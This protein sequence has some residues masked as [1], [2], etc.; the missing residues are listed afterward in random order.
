MCWSFRP[1]LTPLQFQ[2]MSR[3]SPQI[4]LGAI[5]CSV[6]LILCD[7]DAPDC[8]IVYTTDSFCAMT[9]YP[10]NEMLGQNCRFLQ[11]P[12]GRYAGRQIKAVDKLA[13][14]RMRQAIN[15]QD[16]VQLQITN[17]KKSGQ[18]F[19]NFLSIIPIKMAGTSQNFAVGFGVELE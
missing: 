2:I 14:H 1:S 13:I 3:P 6:A 4:E 19:T 10:R 8:P 9:G 16:E 15:N 12:K 17:Y 5:D 18:R 7:L 11:T